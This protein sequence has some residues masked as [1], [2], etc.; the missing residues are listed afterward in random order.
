[1]KKTYNYVIAVC[2]IIIIC[3]C[4]YCCYCCYYCEVTTV[5]IV[6]HAE[7]AATNPADPPLSPAGVARA[8]TLAHVV[9][10]AGIDVIFVTDKQ[11]TQQ[12]AEPTATN[13]SLTPIELDEADTDIL[14]SMVYSDHQGEEILIVGHSHTIPGI[15]EG[16]GI[17]EENLFENDPYDNL[18]ILHIRHC[19]FSYPKFLHLQYGNQS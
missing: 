10:N 3:I 7:K 4:C 19:F 8:Q 2:C 16:F 17:S 18:F 11:R 6:R 12:T 15:L 9:E 5:I 1:M 14:I 13:L